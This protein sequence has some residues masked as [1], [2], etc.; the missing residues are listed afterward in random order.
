MQYRK[1]AF[2]FALAAT[3][4]FQATASDVAKIRIVTDAGEQAVEVDLDS[5]KVGQS[6]Q[7]ASSSG[8]PA[9]VTRTAE[10]LR[11]EVAGKTTEVQLGHAEH[12]SWASDLGEGKQVK[13]I[14]FDHDES[15]HQHGDGEHKK[16]VV[17]RKAGGA[18]GH[19]LSEEEIA[20]LVAE[21]EVKM[22]LDTADGGEKVI[23]TRKVVRE[24]ASQQK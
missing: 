7:L 4:A 8:A 6:R 19:N 21:M 17:I 23:V 2:L 16:V 22:D 11:I 12:A 13:V 1:L 24:D 5:L 9:L 20:E 3:A 15:V 14:H 10:G 18:E